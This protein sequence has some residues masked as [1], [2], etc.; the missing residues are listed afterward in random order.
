MKSI[1]TDSSFKLGYKNAHLILNAY[2]TTFMQQKFFATKPSTV[3]FK[4][5]I[6]HISPLWINDELKV[7]GEYDFKKR[8]GSVLAYANQVHIE[9]EKTTL[10]SQVNI[11]GLLSDNRSTVTGT[12]TLLGGNIHYDM[13]T[14][15]F[16]ADND[17]VVKQD[18]KKSST[19]A[20]LENQVLDI[21]I[22]TQTTSYLQK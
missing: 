21:R 8:Q 11:K 12:L 3:F 7:T 4:D 14:K 9:H 20:L 18:K 16:S 17:I 13:D 2:K 15:T 19:P 22:H 10:T 1:L 5:G 6:I